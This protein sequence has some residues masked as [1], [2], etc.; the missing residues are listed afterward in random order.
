MKPNRD[1]SP[2]VDLVEVILDKGAVVSADIVILVAGI[3]LVGIN[4]RAAIAG[5][6]TMLR[7]GMMQAW[8]ERVREE[9]AVEIEK[10]NRPPLEEDE[11]ILF[12]AFG[13]YYHGEGIYNAWRPGELYLTNKRLF[14]FRKAQHEVLFEAPLHSI[15]ALEIKE[16]D[17][18]NELRLLFKT[19][20]ATYLRTGDLDGLKRAFENLELSIKAKEALVAL[21][22]FK[23]EAG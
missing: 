20:Q 3:P 1:D 13:S 18:F 15:N 21:K 22:F 4:L 5:M 2:L 17:G 12:R 6:E 7:Y 10:M 23:K 14:I 16:S 19:G 11:E 8:D 9:Y